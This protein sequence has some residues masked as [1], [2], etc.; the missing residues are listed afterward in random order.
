M[1][2]Q[3]PTRR[4]PRHNNPP[5]EITKPKQFNNGNIEIINPARSAPPPPKVPVDE[6]MI[7]GRRY[8]VPERVIMLDFWGK[9]SKE[10]EEP[11]D[12]S[13]VLISAIYDTDMD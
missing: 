11:D 10:R 3:H 2:V 4:V 7:N 12:Q 1:D 5:I 6:V 8:R 9:L 13:V